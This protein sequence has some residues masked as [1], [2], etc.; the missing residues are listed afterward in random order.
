MTVGVHNAD[1]RKIRMN[2]AE[3]FKR[4]ASLGL[5]MIAAAILIPCGSHA[6]QSAPRDLTATVAEH[7]PQGW[8]IFGDV[9]QF[10]KENVWEQINGRASFFL[11]YDMIRM[12]HASFVNSTD[13]SQF[14]D[15]SIYDMGTPTHAFGV[16]SSERSQDAPPVDLGRAAY[17][18][19]ASYFIWK[20]RYYVRIISSDVTP[21]FR[22]TAMDLARGIANAL[23]DSGETVWGLITL[24]RK[25]RIPQSVRYYKVNAM[26]LEFMRNTYTAEYRKED[27]VITAFISRHSTANAAGDTVARFNGY[28]KNFGDSIKEETF[29]G[30]RLIVCDMG[31]SFDVAFTKGRL[32]GGVSSAEDHDLAIK[33]AVELWRQLPEDK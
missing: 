12:T 17:R 16:F 25:D 9:K 30:V 27:A 15:L 13:E 18:S 11:A 1:E 6:Q 10:G 24:P 19:D 20:G 14:I 3:K 32:V 23:A 31:G 22:Q 2:L 21:M 26:G 33:S 5:V 28:V 29:G 7:T 4:T 8:Q